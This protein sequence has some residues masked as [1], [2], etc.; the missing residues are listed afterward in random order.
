[1]KFLIFSDLHIH[2]HSDFDYPVD[3]TSSRLLDCLNVIDKVKSYYDKYRCEAVLFCGDMFHVPRFVETSTYEPAFRRL[4]DLT[5]NVKQFIAISGNHDKSDVTRGGPS[6]SSVYPASRLK[7]SIIVTKQS[8][9]IR[10]S[11]TV[12]HCLPYLKDEKEFT[13]SIKRI[14][15]KVSSSDHNVVLTH[16]SL[17][18]AENGP[19]EI[20]LREAWSIKDLRKTG[21]YIFCGHHHHPQR[22]NSRAI[23]VGSPIQHNMLDRGDNRGLVVYDSDRQQVK[24]IWLSF[25]RFFLFEILDKDHLEWFLGTEWERGIE[26][27]YVR[28]LF[29]F[30]P[31]RD[32]ISRIEDQLT[33]FKVRGSE[34]KIQR[35]P[36]NSVRNEKLTLQLSRT[37]DFK[38]AIP[39]YVDHVRDKLLNRKRLIKVGEKLLEGR[40]NG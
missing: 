10:L 21:D 27:G 25:S 9:S 22:L 4:E 38:S 2:P 29:R 19:N 39:T 24:R 15:S 11:N 13:D 12:I 17:R 37:N 35:A 7:N 34:I 31:P 5:D 30:I 32:V 23:V 14:K 28:F 33:S 8:E 3:H 1:M 40:E 36:L 6:Y 18:E 16:C 20:R 26:N